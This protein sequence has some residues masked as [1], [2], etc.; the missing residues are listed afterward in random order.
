MTVV[1][2][3][4]SLYDHPGLAAGLRAYLPTLVPP[5]VLVPGG[6]P[7]ADAAR[8]LDAVHRLGDEAA[9]WLA[10]RTLSA[11]ALFLRALVGDLPGV[12]VLDGYDFA[13]AN[14][15]LPHTWAVTTDSLAA[16]TARRSGAKLVLLKSVDILPGTDWRD[17][18]EYGW[19]DEYFPTAAAGVAVEAI[20]FRRILDGGLPNPEPHRAHPR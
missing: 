18:A 15:V 7:F 19:V 13:A 20:N 14:D 6:G 10:L 2:V 3:G 1:K 16:Y 9:H 12:Y 8:T 11:A 17:A 4:G 5:V